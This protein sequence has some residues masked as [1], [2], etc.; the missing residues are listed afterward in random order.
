LLLASQMGETASRARKRNQEDGESENRDSGGKGK[1]E[2]LARFSISPPY[3]GSVSDQRAA[4]GGVTA[5]VKKGEGKQ[6][7]I[8]P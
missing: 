7:Y 5:C 8:P 3:Y 2:T 1:G 6:P 4:N